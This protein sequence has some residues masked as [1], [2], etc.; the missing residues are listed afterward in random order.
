M[1]Q[2]TYGIAQSGLQ[3]AGTRQAVSADNTAN[4][5]STLSRQN[6]QT[7]AEPYEAKR[8]EQT[9]LASGGVRASVQKKD[10]AT[11]PMPDISHHAAAKGG[12]TEYPNV[13]TA[14][15]VVSQQLATYDFKANLVSLRRADEAMQSLLD[16]T[17]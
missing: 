16:I 15:E 2:S 1:L 5:F 12:V 9:S 14:E 13:D 4:Q 7:V 8:V 11:Q 3:A 10:P 17:A 6:G